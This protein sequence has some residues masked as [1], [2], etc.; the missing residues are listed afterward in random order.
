MGGERANC[1]ELWRGTVEFSVFSPEIFAVH[2]HVFIHNI[3]L[4]I[5]NRDIQILGRERPRVRDLT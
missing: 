4:L 5:H 2:I 1:C 3:D